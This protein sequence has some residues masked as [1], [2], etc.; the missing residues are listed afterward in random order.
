MVTQTIGAHSRMTMHPHVQYP[1]SRFGCGTLRPV[2]LFGLGL[3]LSL[4]A[5]NSPIQVARADETSSAVEQNIDSDDSIPSGRL[6]GED[7]DAFVDAIA[8]PDATNDAM[9]QLQFGAYAVDIPTTYTCRTVN[10]PDSKDDVSSAFYESADGD[11]LLSIVH[12]PEVN[13][14]SPNQLE[15][16]L[17]TFGNI[18]NLFDSIEVADGSELRLVNFDSG[19]KGYTEV[20]YGLYDGVRIPVVVFGFQNSD[21]DL[22]MISGTFLSIEVSYSRL[23][24][25]YDIAGTVSDGIPL[26]SLSSSKTANNDQAEPART[27][28]RGEQ[29]A[30]KKA[31]SYLSSMA[32]SRSGLIKQLEYEG[33]TSSEAEYAVNHCNADWNEQA[34]IKAEKY[35][36]IMAF[37]RK[38]LIEQL[39]Y[40]GFTHEQALAAATAVGL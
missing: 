13:I 20:Q 1:G 10:Q 11:M 14:A 36:D 33:Y 38:G 2:L 39:E 21:G 29:N 5:P 35:L 8:S 17:E 25:L 4:A 34:I 24:E 6:S 12:L 30:L 28:T 7:L 9:C 16:V 3:I 23:E 15:T 18:V 26:N 27:A 31:Q 37:S 32:F 19:S 40:E 22:L